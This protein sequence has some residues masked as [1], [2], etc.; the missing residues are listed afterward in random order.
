MPTRRHVLK[1]GVAAGAAAAVGGPRLLTGSAAASRATRLDPT[2][3][4]KYATRLFILPAMPR[5]GTSGRLKF[6]VAA[7]RFTQQ[8]LPS[9]FPRTTVFGWGSTAHSGTNRA[10]CW[11]LENQV[12]RETQVT[13]V[14]QL[15]TS[16]GN[17]V[18]SLLTVD[19]TIHWANPPGGV[20]GRDSEPVFTSTPPPYT[21][22]LPLVVHQH[23]GHT[24][25]ES[26]GYPEAWTLP[27]AGNIPGG[28]AR[29]GSFYDRFKEEARQ[30]WGVNWSPGNFI[31]V[32]PNDQRAGTDWFHDHSLGMTRTSVH[33]GLI[34][35]FILRGGPS[36]T[37]PGVLP[38]P[39]PMPGDP[40]GKRYYEIMLTFQNQS[41]NTD[42]SLRFPTSRTDFGDTQGPFRPFS[43]IPP[44]WN[45]NFIGDTMNVNGNVWPF[46]EVE[47]RRYRF[48]LLDANNI[49]DL[50]LKVV[51]D[52][53]AARP[54]QAA[55]PIWV[56]GS[57]GGFLPRPQRLDGTQVLP[58][59][60][61]ERYDI[62]LDFT[63][64]AVGTRLH[65]INESPATNPATNGQIMQ[66]RVVPLQSPDR[67]VPP[68]Q[69]SLPGFQQIG[70][71]SNVRRVSFQQQPSVSQPNV[72]AGIFR[73]GT[74]DANGN[75]V[76]MDWHEPIVETPRL[77]TTEVWEVHNVTNGGHSFHIHLVQFQ[78]VNRQAIGSTTLQPPGPHETGDK[79]VFFAPGRTVSR[80][81]ATFDLRSLYVWHCHF[82]DHEDHNMMRPW[83]VV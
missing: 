73:A 55:I 19:P 35:Y 83:Q 2:T 6:S 9:G 50:Q 43:D 69:L 64:L 54:Q 31:Y 16:T 20:E 80:F 78:V 74:V 32:Y 81:K 40:A 28:F 3:I 68:D 34:G 29:V 57:D 30:R 23:G 47:P 63:G 36:D 61:A 44:Y 38:G 22:P 71:H 67:T 17:F 72:A 11:T 45:P 75:P 48:R 53:L 14:N 66:F 10:P 59:F 52:P 39:A 37:L 70:P 27:N 12:D 1:G 76:P 46:L 51:R 21:G 62:I 25:E 18:P 15:M 33:S 24:F 77:N 5:T 56:I 7:R 58:M 41:F 8:V 42:G 49:L 26:D 13:W 79:D 65:L 60:T 82:V 4:P